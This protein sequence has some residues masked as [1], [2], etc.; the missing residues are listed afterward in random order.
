MRVD[1]LVTRLGALPLNHVSYVVDIANDFGYDL[2]SVSREFGIG[3]QIGL[4]DNTDLPIELYYKFLGK[5][6]DTVEIPSFGV[7][8]GQKFSLFDYGVLGYACISSPTFRHLLKTFFRFQQIVG[9]HITF[10][11]SLRVEGDNAIIEIFCANPD[12]KLTR[13]DIEEAVG[14]WSTS[15]IEVFHGEDIVFNRVNFSF[16]KPSYAGEIKQL[17]G[18]AVHY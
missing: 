14:Q 2:S 6:L 3:E 12:E 13:F 18:C 5:V 11:E 9:G 7:R 8:V 17:L 1:G 4:Q 10:Q 16:S 15:V